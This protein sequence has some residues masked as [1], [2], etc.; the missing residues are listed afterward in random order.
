MDKNSDDE[1]STNGDIEVSNTVTFSNP[2]TFS[3]IR[4]K[5]YHMFCMNEIFYCFENN[6]LAKFI[7]YEDKNNNVH[8][9]NVKDLSDLKNKIFIRN[10]SYNVGLI[11]AL[12]AYHKI[13]F[14]NN[15]MLLANW[16]LECLLSFDKNELVSEG[17]LFLSNFNNFIN[18]SVFYDPTIQY[19]TG[20]IIEHFELPA[21]DLLRFIIMQGLINGE[22]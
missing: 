13:S 9:D 17:I 8:G 20:Q 14:I 11:L 21:L 3:Y 5:D 10:L 19:E 15:D 22:I 7:R 6:N 12:L 2:T 4:L 1:L 18:I 16:W